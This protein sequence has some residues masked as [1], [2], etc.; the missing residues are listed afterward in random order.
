MQLRGGA[1][2]SRVGAPHRDLLFG[3]R[4]SSILE[5]KSSRMVWQW[6]GAPCA[7]TFALLGSAP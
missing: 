2:A 4:G 6:I 5:R 7:R 1:G 3:Y